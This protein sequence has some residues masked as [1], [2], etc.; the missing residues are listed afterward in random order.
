MCRLTHI[1]CIYPESKHYTIMLFS[2]QF[3]FSICFQNPCVW[4][5]W[6]CNRETEKERARETEKMRTLSSS[7]TAHGYLCLSCFHL[8][9]LIF[10]VC[11]SESSEDKHKHSIP[12]WHPSDRLSIKISKYQNKSKDSCA[13]RNAKTH[14][15]L[16]HTNSL[17]PLSTFITPAHP[18]TMTH[19]PISPTCWLYIA[20]MFSTE[21]KWAVTTVA[22]CQ[23]KKFLHNL[24]PPTQILQLCETGDH[25]TAINHFLHP[26]SLRSKTVYDIKI[27][28]PTVCTV[29]LSWS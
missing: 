6:V 20:V 4:Y 7:W 26:S 1:L 29:A 2:Y 15:H 17:F 16:L 12:T 25:C 24:W 10:C 9:T 21:R 5:V 19:S 28:Y 14:S 23:V 22:R 3:I 18:K 27:S 11:T 8:F 13:F